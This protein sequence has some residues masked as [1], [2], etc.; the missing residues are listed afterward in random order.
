RLPFKVIEEKV[1]VRALQHF[2]TEGWCVLQWTS[3]R[4]PQKCEKFPELSPIV[5][6]CPGR[7]EKKGRN[8][9]LFFFFFWIRGCGPSKLENPLA[10][11]SGFTDD[12]RQVVAHIRE[13]Y[14]KRP[15]FGVGY[16]LGS[17]YLGKYL[18]EESNDCT[19]SGAV[20]CTALIDLPACGYLLQQSWLGQL[21]DHF[22][23]K[24]VVS[25]VMY[26]ANS[27]FETGKPPERRPFHR[28]FLQ[29]DGSLL[30]KKKKFNVGTLVWIGDASDEKNVSENE[31]VKESK[32]NQSDDDSCSEIKTDDSPRKAE[33]HANASSRLLF[34]KDHTT[35]S[36]SKFHPKRASQMSTLREFDQYITSQ[37]FGYRSSNE[38]YFKSS[39]GY[40]LQDIQVPTLMI[41]SQNDVIVPIGVVQPDD[42]WG[43]PFLAAVITRYGSHG[44]DWLTGVF[45]F[46][47]WSAEVVVEY[48]RA[49]LMLE[50]QGTDMIKDEASLV[51]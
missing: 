1:K 17:N 50:Q 37:E 4:F 6:I 42:F 30:S 28:R 5:I 26:K 11:S 29:K 39:C 47:S 34:H 20:L 27:V 31:E 43:N 23:T 41:N 22:L 12:L 14:P 25:V 10:Y 13:K 48:F 35:K 32:E 8:K 19:L 18:G 40:Y 15:L 3:D 49:I 33:M 24:A 51:K 21:Y 46:K 7:I 45:N 2:L 9:K 36:Q 38:Y 44:M 16:S